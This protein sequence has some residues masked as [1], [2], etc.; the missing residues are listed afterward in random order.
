LCVAL[1]LLRPQRRIGRKL[2]QD[3]P[4]DTPDLLTVEVATIGQ[5]V[6]GFLPIDRLAAR[7][8]RR[9]FSCR[10]QAE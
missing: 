9:V 2:L 6:P 5:D 8:V 7:G 4:G 10:S 3:R 1:S